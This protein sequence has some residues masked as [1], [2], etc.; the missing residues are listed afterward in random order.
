MFC[1]DAFFT[2][3]FLTLRIRRLRCF[4]KIFLQIRKNANSVRRHFPGLKTHVFCLKNALPLPVLRKDALRTPLFRYAHGRKILPLCVA[5]LCA[6][7][8]RGKPF[9]THVGAWRHIPCGFNDVLNNFF[10]NKWLPKAV[11]M[12]KRINFVGGI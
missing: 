6:S 2:F 9:H 4:G 5:P 7:A 1:V 3:Y 12:R 8:L 10:C 11:C